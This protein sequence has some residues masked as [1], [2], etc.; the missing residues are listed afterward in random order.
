MANA[1]IPASAG[2]QGSVWLAPDYF[3]FDDRFPMARWLAVERSSMRKIIPV[4]SDIT[5]VWTAGLGRASLAAPLTLKGVT[6]ESFYFCLKVLLADQVR[7]DAQIS[8]IDRD[9]RLWTIRTDNQLA[10]GTTS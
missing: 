10:N 4:Q 6:T 1:V 7:V 3:F 5:P 8:R 2:V 9:L